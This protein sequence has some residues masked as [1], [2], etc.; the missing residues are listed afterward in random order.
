[1]GRLKALVRSE[2]LYLWRLRGVLTAHLTQ[3]QS[4]KTVLSLGSIQFN[5]HSFNLTQ[6][7]WIHLVIFLSSLTLCSVAF[8]SKH[9][10][11]GRV[12]NRIRGAKLH[13]YP[14]KRVHHPGKYLNLE[15]DKEQFKSHSCTAV[16]GR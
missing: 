11:R 2:G 7:P 12:G 3:T 8:W 14:H 6:P 4:S 9:Y 16:F 1:M 13:E 15:L 5:S 10:N